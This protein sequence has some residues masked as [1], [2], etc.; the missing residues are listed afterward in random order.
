[1]YEN[2]APFY[3]LFGH[4]KEETAKRVSFVT[5]Y[6]GGAEVSLIDVGSAT[7]EVAIALAEEGHKVAAFEPAFPFYSIL[8]DR[9]RA[10]RD[11][12]DL[13]SAYPLKLEDLSGSLQADFALVSSV[14]S[15]LPSNAK[16]VLLNGL[17]GHLKPGATLVFNCVQ[18]N[19]GRQDQPLMTV[20]ET[21]IG[22]LTYRHSASSRGIDELRREVVFQ[23]DI[24]RREE[25]L[26]TYTDHFQLC[27]D[28]LE[29]MRSRLRECGF[30]A[31]ET[32]GSFE[33]NPYD[34]SGSGF[35]IVAK[36]K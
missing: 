8:L 6:L 1:M 12:R 20:A 17:A 7:G 23:F 14:F 27:L 22:D 4:G 19:P 24:R 2:S 30:T 34:A 3:D 32:W 15:H 11:L 36:R 13:V 21:K 5:K 28:D 18:V 31:L 25:V 26:S 29:Q 9:L 16:T 33:R 10:R 35:V